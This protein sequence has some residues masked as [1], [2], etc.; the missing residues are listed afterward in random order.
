MLTKKISFHRIFNNKLF[1]L[2][3]SIQNIF[4]LFATSLIAG[5]KSAIKKKL[6]L[7]KLILINLHNKLRLKLLDY[8][9]WLI[10]VNE[11]KNVDWY[12]VKFFAL[13]IRFAQC[14]MMLECVHKSKFVKS[15]LSCE[16][17]GYGIPS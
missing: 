9:W 12:L 14:R 13:S 8:S 4:F 16:P 1:F 17:I 7:R 6:K 2:E 11:K 3:K 15:H 10:L 5:S